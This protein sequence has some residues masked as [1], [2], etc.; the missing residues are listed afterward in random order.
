[1]NILKVLREDSEFDFH[2][3]SKNIFNK[4]FNN[5]NFN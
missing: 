1:M 4:Q 2:L 5:Q 3:L